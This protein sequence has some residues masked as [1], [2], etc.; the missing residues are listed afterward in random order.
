MELIQP[1]QPTKESE[2]SV[3]TQMA[4]LWTF[5]HHPFWVYAFVIFCISGGLTVMIF[6]I[7][8]LDNLYCRYF[9]TIPYHV[10]RRRLRSL[11]KPKSL[12]DQVFCVLWN[13]IVFVGLFVGNVIAL[14]CL[15][16]LVVTLGLLMLNLIPDWTFGF[17]V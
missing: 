2:I 11:E 8:G 9:S 15:L 6:L 10:E 13:I 12:F 17:S 5:R 7:G 1:I 3:P 16:I 14:G 4:E